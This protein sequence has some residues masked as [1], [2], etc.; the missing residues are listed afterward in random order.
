VQPSSP[1]IS[2]DARSDWRLAFAAACLGGASAGAFVIIDLFG[3]GVRDAE[4]LVRIAHLI[5]FAVVAI[6]LWNRRHRPTRRLCT[7]AAV[8]MW[9]PFLASLWL[10]EETAA[11]TGQLGQVWQ[12]FVGHK[13]IF[14]VTAAMFPRPAW[15]GA[16]MLVAFGLHATVLWFHLDLGAPTANMPV[17]EPWATIGYLG[18]AWFLF[19]YRIHH[20]RTEAELAR[21]RAEARVL[22]MSADAFLV[23]RDL[24]NT[25]LQV[26]EL[27]IALLR[28]RHPDEDV[29]LDSASRALVRLRALRDQ[30][31]VSRV[32]SASPDPDALRRLRMAAAGDPA[33]RAARTPEP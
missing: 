3:A 1:N 18:I 33:D 21:V 30:L 28:R 17:D 22:E 27:A 29:I 19:G 2:T 31:P 7:I 10:S 8:V 9:M 16:L 14:F 23:V 5:I 25:P 26:L 24:A 12:P 6:V 4:F 11:L 13:I 20:G 32:T 15:V